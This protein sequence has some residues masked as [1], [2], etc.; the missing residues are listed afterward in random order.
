MDGMVRVIVDTG[1][2]RWRRALVKPDEL[3]RFL[4]GETPILDWFTEGDLSPA[5]VFAEDIIFDTDLLPEVSQEAPPFSGTAWFAD[6]AREAA[7]F[8]RKVARE[9]GVNS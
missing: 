1:D 2:K 6:S 5:E 8:L 4:G 7:D 9:Q 3:G